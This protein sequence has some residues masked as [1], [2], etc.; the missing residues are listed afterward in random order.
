MEPNQMAELVENAADAVESV[1]NGGGAENRRTLVSRL[2]SM[3]R[4][5][6]QRFIGDIV[7]PLVRNMAE[8]TE[9]EYDARNEYAC[10][11]CKAMMKG[12]KAEFP[13][14]ANGDCQLP[15]I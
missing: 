11:V 9:N 5:L 1:V 3:H 14:I 10:R 13:Y 6:Q 7:I 15:L 12:L 2:G 4:T 8:R